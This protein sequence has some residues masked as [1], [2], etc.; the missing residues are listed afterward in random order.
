MSSP[1]PL[2]DDLRVVVVTHTLIDPVP[3]L[4]KTLTSVYQLLFV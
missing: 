4:Q 1:A 3:D 2:L